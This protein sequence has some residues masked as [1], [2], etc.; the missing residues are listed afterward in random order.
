M[1]I[2]KQSNLYG[3]AVGIKLASVFCLFDSFK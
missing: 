1:I 3:A 2:K